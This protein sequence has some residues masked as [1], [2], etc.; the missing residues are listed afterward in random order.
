MR[1]L[2]RIGILQIL[3][4]FL[5]PLP[6]IYCLSKTMPRN[7]RVS[8]DRKM[9]IL[10]QEPTSELYDIEKVQT[11]YLE[12]NQTN[13]YQQLLNNYQKKIDIPANLTFNGNTYF[14]VGVRFRGNTSYMMTQNSKK[15]PFNISIDYQDETQRI[16][17]D[18]KSVV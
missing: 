4:A 15:K 14:N 1:N 12:F 2:K 16:E 10:Y 13:W 8:D 17:Q 11:I 6:S 5:I 18:R 3:I 7:M 9:L